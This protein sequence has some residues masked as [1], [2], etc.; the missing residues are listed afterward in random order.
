M[1]DV[2]ALKHAE[3]VQATPSV[4]EDGKHYI[5]LIMM[6][7]EMVPMSSGAVAKEYMVGDEK[8]IVT[9]DHLIVKIG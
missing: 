2:V 8:F 6:G 5:G 4:R 9:K 3:L 7:G 1:G